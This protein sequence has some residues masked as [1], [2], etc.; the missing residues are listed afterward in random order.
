[1]EEK[2]KG[3]EKKSKNIIKIPLYFHCA[4]TSV[5]YFLRNP[6]LLYSFHWKE[7]RSLIS[8]AMAFR[9][10]ISEINFI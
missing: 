10:R 7:K 3:R 1:L 8:Q 5:G 4:L 9:L 2:G 6:G